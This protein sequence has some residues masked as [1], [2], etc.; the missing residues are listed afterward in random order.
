MHVLTDQSHRLLQLTLE[1]PSLPLKDAARTLGMADDE[2]AGALTELTEIGLVRRLE[3]RGEFVTLAPEA[4]LAQVIALQQEDIQERLD[5]LRRTESTLSVLG[6]SLMR[7]RAERERPALTHRLV[8]P[9]EISAALEGVAA[10][11]RHEVLSMHPGPPLPPPMLKDSM[12]RNREVIDRG[13]VMRSIHLS[14]MLK[15]P[16]GRAHLEGLRDAGAEVRVASV[17]PFRLVMVDGLVAYVPE[18]P[19][20][21]DLGADEQREM[22]ALEIRDP[23]LI[24]LFRAVFEFCWVHG[25]TEPALGAAPAAEEA[26]EDLDSRELSMVRMLGQGLKDDAIARSL[27]ISSRTLRRMMTEVMRKLNADSR[28]QAGAH[29]AVRGWLDA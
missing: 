21:D 8:G 24:A 13:A 14:T 18:Q 5:A 12:K 15:V 11:A 27:G 6:A 20:D 4:V 26:Q 23:S 17:L 22:A 1:D 3:G 16:H 19:R 9:K 28:F 7:Q 2:L 10:Q 29:A 25:S